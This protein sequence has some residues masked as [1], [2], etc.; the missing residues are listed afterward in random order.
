[1]VT[2]DDLL[3]MQRSNPPHSAM[4]CVSVQI[5]HTHITLVFHPSSPDQY[6][7]HRGSYANTLYRSGWQERMLQEEAADGRPDHT[8][9]HVVLLI[10][11]QLT[12]SL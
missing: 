9:Q 3:V 11:T 10:M 8:V 12:F 5:P 7:V 1:M 6:Y 4:S 2:F